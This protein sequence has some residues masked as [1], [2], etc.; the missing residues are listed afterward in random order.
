[1]LTKT[2]KITLPICIPE[3]LCHLPNMNFVVWHNQQFIFVRRPFGNVNSPPQAL[4]LAWQILREIEYMIY[5]LPYHDPRGRR[6]FDA[7][8]ILLQI[9]EVLERMLI[10]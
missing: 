3:P 10:T 7:M 1:M 4:A 2:S 6:L 8:F 5:D 9:I